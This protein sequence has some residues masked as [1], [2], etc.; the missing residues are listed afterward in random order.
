MDWIERLNRV[1]GYI[2]EH[3][4]DGID[5]DE[6]A[7]IMCC[8]TYHFQRMFAFINQVTLSEY[9]RR[10]K[11]SLAAVDLQNGRKIID[12]AYKYGYASPTAFSRAF[13]NIHGIAPSRAKEKGAVLKSYPSLC[14]KFIIK[15]MEELNYRIENKDGFRVAGI[16]RPLD[17]EMEQ[18]FKTVPDMWDRAA[19][20]GTLME[21]LSLK[22][23]EPDGLLGRSAC[24]S[25]AKWSYYIAVPTSADIPAGFVEYYIPASMWAVFTGRGTNHSL[26]NLERRVITE[27]LPFS[28]YDYGD[29]PD[30][31]YYIQ[32]DPR[33]AVYEYWLPIK[34]K[35]E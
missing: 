19:A 7:K 10:R 31:E 4:L 30:I 5:Y 25:S 35:K 11:M 17:R 27:W 28:G 2:E 14:F 29:T 16:S 13:R 21:L 1:A 18:N 12:V 26:Q 23:G 24:G 34:N 15:G 20:D 8:S 22:N 3:L 9:I 32:A 33:D 6:L